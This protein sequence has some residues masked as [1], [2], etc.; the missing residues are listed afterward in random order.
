MDRSKVSESGGSVKERATVSNRTNNLSKDAFIN[1][2]QPT[3]S[4]Q[5][6][7]QQLWM[8][9][10]PRSKPAVSQYYPVSWSL[11][12][13]F[14][15]FL[16]THCVPNYAYNIKIW[17]TNIRSSQVCTCWWGICTHQCR[18]W[19]GRCCERGEAGRGQHWSCLTVVGSVASACVW[20]TS[21]SSPPVKSKPGQ[22]STIPI[23]PPLTWYV[24]TMLVNYIWDE[25]FLKNQCKSS[26]FF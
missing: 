19:K 4:Q 26:T 15:F 11:N 1:F 9:C 7:W 23:S 8:L 25:V 3:I 18:Q 24:Q 6:W 13:T 21:S 2:V 14:F 5:R 20:S 12:H 16:T 22:S 10:Q 17:W